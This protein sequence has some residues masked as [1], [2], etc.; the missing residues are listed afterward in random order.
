MTNIQNLSNN[1]YSLLTSSN[2]LLFSFQTTT[3]NSCAQCNERKIKTI[4]LIWNLLYHV[5]G[6]E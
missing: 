6:F 3:K 2:L 1:F 5:N 4:K